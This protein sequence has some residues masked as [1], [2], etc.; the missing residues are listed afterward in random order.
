MHTISE[1]CYINANLCTYQ[2]SLV[3]VSFKILRLIYAHVELIIDPLLP[4][5]QAGFKYGR[6]TI[7]LNSKNSFLAKKK[8]G[9]V[10]VDLTAAYDIVSVHSLT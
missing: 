8:A 4:R 3:C 6:L 1:S 2:V 10:F 9:T 7:D 5:E